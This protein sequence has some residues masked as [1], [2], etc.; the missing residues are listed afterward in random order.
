M[1]QSPD[2]TVEITIPFCRPDF[3]DAERRAIELAMQ[4]GRLHG[5]G[6]IN[7]QCEEFL[8]NVTGCDRAF[9]TPSCT[10]AL[11]MM[12]LALDLK[13]GDEVIM[14]S[15]TFVSTANAFAL[16][17]VVPVFVDID[18]R[19][20]NIT[21]SNA[22]AAI[23]PKTRAIM[24][25]H[26]GGVGCDME[27]FESICQDHNLVL[28]EDAAQAIGAYWNDRHL[29]SFGSMGAISFHHT[30]NVT[31]GEG[32]ALL[33]NDPELVLTNEFIREKGTDRTEFLRGNVGKYEWKRLGSSYLMSEVT[34][35]VLSVQLARETEL[36][37]SRL[38]VWRRYDDSLSSIVP[39]TTPYIPPQ[40]RHNGHV[41]SIC[42]ETTELRAKCA[43]FLRCKGIIAAPHYVPLH[44]TPAGLKYGYAVGAMQ[45]TLRVS[46]TQLRLP[47]YSSMTHAEQDKVIES[48]ISF[49]DSI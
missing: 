36:T 4:S 45:E 33:V 26:Y 48:L 19:T 2:R 17:G 27:A 32:G 5:G 37:R 3:D 10:A 41:Y 21:P 47:L 31:C 22:R 43:E 29:G 14:P 1:R 16:R 25:V 23:T 11:E 28:L 20:F 7:R 49:I 35:A 13:P 38:A 30:K 15:F 8:E 34:A 12:P 39:I 44:L 6:A 46:S 9:I 18:G 24:V 42:F 40:A